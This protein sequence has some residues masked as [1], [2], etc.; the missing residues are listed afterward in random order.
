M[1]KI[2]L[3]WAYRF[4]EIHHKVPYHKCKPEID[5]WKLWTVKVLGAKNGTR[6]NKFSWYEPFWNE[7]PEKGHTTKGRPGTITGVDLNHLRMRDRKRDQK[8][9]F[10]WCPYN[11]LRSAWNYTA[12]CH[13]A[14]RPGL[15]LGYVTCI[16]STD[17]E[18]EILSGQNI[19]TILIRQF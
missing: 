13:R 16:E 12:K 10:S 18:L 14:R 15:T 11:N 3:V 7:G 4:Y 19:F 5:F 17:L 9:A 6:N 1:C 8:P 2:N